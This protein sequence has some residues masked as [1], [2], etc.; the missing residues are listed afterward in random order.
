MNKAEPLLTFITSLRHPDT[1]DAYAAAEQ[2]LCRSL[3]GLEAQTDRRYAAVVVS[4][5]AFRVPSDLTVPVT[6]VI[7]D[8]PPAPDWD[9]A[10]LP[11]EA[12][13]KID[14]GAKLAVALSQVR[15]GHVMVLD[16]D[17]FVSRRMTNFVAHNQDAA[18]WYVGSGFRYDAG[19][20]LLRRQEHFNQVCGTSLIY[21]RALLPSFSLPDGFSIGDVFDALGE[22]RVLNELGSHLYLHERHAL[23]RLPFRGAVYC[24]NNGHNAS[25]APTLN[26]GRPLTARTA[27]E[28]GI[29]QP[30]KLRTWLAMPRAV[31]HGGGRKLTRVLAGLR[32]NRP[33]AVG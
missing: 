5:R 24:V 11:R 33:P 20:G 28:F 6:T 16:A 1:T 8:F 14:K 18:G 25:S 10:T 26:Y 15:G 3:R 4:N 30:A 2:S 32:R 22:D 12:G 9:K 7:V 31:V 29:E 27:A 19:T 17:D 13:V 23:A 21:A